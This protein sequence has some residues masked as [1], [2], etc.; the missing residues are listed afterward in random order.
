MAKISRFFL[1]ASAA[2]ITSAN[3][4][5]HHDS[6]PL[7]DH[8]HDGNWVH[9]NGIGAD[10]DRD[11]NPATNTRII[12]FIADAKI[13]ADDPPYD[14]IT[15]EPPPG[16]HG[17]KIIQDY[18]ADH[19]VK[20]SKGLSWQV[21]EGQ[22][23]FLYDTMCTYEA[24]TSGKFAAGYLSYLNFPLAMEFEKPVCVVTM[25]I[26]PT[27]GKEGEP[28]EFKIEGW[29]ESGQQLSTASIEFEWTN[30]TVRWRNMAGAFF[31]DQRAKKITVSMR[32]L[33]KKESS[34]TLRYLIDDLAF[35]DDGCDAALDDIEDRTGVDLRAQAEPVTLE[36][37]PLTLEIDL[38]EAP[39]GS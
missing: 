27:G 38:A 13:A 35:V 22:R 23:R 19:G 24:P 9:E 26:Y 1:A 5:P 4:H 36:D 21:C 25:S 8:D 10:P 32:S 11:T 18:Y 15:F 14:V 31:V 34:K 28:F 20:F 37:P 16:E 2:L 17:E 6:D 29:T 39:E 30:N 12:P 7:A 33:D 3:A